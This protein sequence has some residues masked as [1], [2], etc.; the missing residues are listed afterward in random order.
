MLTF[1]FSLATQTTLLQFFNLWS[2][3]SLLNRLWSEYEEEDRR[4]LIPVSRVRS[5]S[6]LALKS[7]QK[8]RILQKPASYT[9]VSMHNNQPTRDSQKNTYK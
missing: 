6:P 4:Q 7:L 3:R 9:H 2:K 5:K 1:M 8:E